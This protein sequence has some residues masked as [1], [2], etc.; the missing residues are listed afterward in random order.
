MQAAATAPS[1]ELWRWVQASPA[2]HLVSRR[3]PS[4][5][6][7]SCPNGLVLHDAVLARS[8]LRGRSEEAAFLEDAALA[9]HLRRG[10]SFVEPLGAAAGASAAWSG[11]GA[12]LVRRGLPKFFDLD[13]DAL[14]AA[15]RASPRPAPAPEPGGGAARLLQSSRTGR[16]TRV[17][18]LSKA[19]GENAQSFFAPAQQWV[20]C[21]KNVA[22]L[23]GVRADISSPQWS[24]HRYRFAR[25]VAEL[26]F[27]QLDP[28]A[29]ER[30][31]SLREA[32]SSRTLVGELVGGSA[33]LVDYAGLRTIIWFAIVPHHGDEACWP[34]SRSLAFLGE[35][36]LPVVSMELAGPSASCPGE[37][38]ETLCRMARATAAGSVKEDGEGYVVYVVAEGESTSD[39]SGRAAS[40]AEVI[41]IGK[42]KT[43]EYRLLRKLREK[44]KRFAR[45]GGSIT[46]DRVVSEYAAEVRGWALDEQQAEAH[47]LR[48]GR[49]CRYIFAEDLPPDVVDETFLDTLA[50]ADQHEGVEEPRPVAP[51]LCILSP[52]LLVGQ[53]LL[54]RLR[55]M[56]RG[57]HA[58]PG[59]EDL[60]P[61]TV[62][63]TGGASAAWH[64]AA[65]G[66]LPIYLGAV[67]SAVE[68]CCSL[69]PTDDP[70]GAPA[71]KR[72]KVAAGER[73]A[74]SACRAAEQLR[75]RC[76]F[77]LW[78]WSEQGCGRSLELAS[79][80]AAGG[81]GSHGGGLV[82]EGARFRRQRSPARRALLAKW[83]AHSGRL[84]AALPRPSALWLPQAPALDDRRA[85][86]TIAESYR[87]LQ[88]VA[89]EGPRAVVVAALPVGLPGMGKSSLMSR[90][91]RLCGSSARVLFQQGLR[92]T[93]G[94]RDAPAATVQ[95]P[96][97][98]AVS[99][100]SSDG[101]TAA[102]MRACGVS[103]ESCTPEELN[104]CRRRGA[105]R[106]R[107]S[108][109]EFLR[110]AKDDST[111][112]AEAGER[113]SV[114]P[115]YLLL[116]D[117]NYPP[118]ALR[119]EVEV[120][121]G[122]APPGLA[123]RLRGLLLG[124]EP[125]CVPSAEDPL[126]LEEEREFGP[127]QYP[128]GLDEVVECAARLMLR[129]GHDTLEGGETA[130]FVLLSFLQLHK[131]RQVAGET[132]GVDFV[133]VPFLSAA[134][135]LAS[136]ADASGG[137]PEAPWRRLEVR[138]LAREALRVLRPFGDP[139]PP[140]PALAALRKCLSSSGLR[141]P[142]ELDRRVHAQRC[143]EDA[144]RALLAAPQEK[145]AS[146]EAP[147]P[148]RY[149]ALSVHAQREELQSLLRRAS[150]AMAASAG[151]GRLDEPFPPQLYRRPAFLHVT[152]L[153]L[154][155]VVPS[156]AERRLL[157][158]SRRLLREAAAFDC[159][160]THLVCARGALACAV[161][162]ADRLRASGVP[163]GE[164]ARPHV[165]LCT[166]APWQP[167]HSGDVLA[168]VAAASLGAG[169]ASAG[170]EEAAGGRWLK[171]LRV[172]SGLLD[173]FVFRLPEARVLR[174]SPL[175][176]L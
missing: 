123:L 62:A 160:V 19:N 122:L 148:V 143:A 32:L 116:L 137:S 72:R 2:V 26:W 63:A 170:Q 156:E 16:G 126:V 141:C 135:Q 153:Y 165:T 25:T 145:G 164:A 73:Q 152:T 12:T 78:G 94:L 22:L 161:V 40:E 65:A 130:L 117:K 70:P 10:L 99:L 107:A 41:W 176:L 27:D 36:G 95:I 172:G 28:L 162:D 109:E 150:A 173:V 133:G 167:R 29:E 5:A 71:G 100:L 127:W 131:G 53:E 68:Q 64:R 3:L 59:G 169:G 50:S 168:A 4:I 85:L 90:L 155:G 144:A 166:R 151:A 82:G 110:F 76:L 6:A 67:P 84:L 34:P 43:I 23:A 115:V 80:P 149:V 31:S 171:A 54:G 159:A 129:S 74:L 14:G 106:Y 89:T 33:H 158:A 52:P 140:G 11:D 46:V 146:A 120:L 118:A 147:L 24:E 124:A 105:E 38:L 44:A 8:Y 119:R 17:L 113:P 1:A 134:G 35:S 45:G 88:A 79:G 37:A 92:A 75:D 7:P 66:H 81:A 57:G 97:L 86:S 56:L 136:W 69:G 13:T 132:P 93:A 96:R 175:R 30:R 112:L 39:G 58:E 48:L 108:I 51:A 15:L 9:R 121:S 77:V 139:G 83:R 18:K 101:F 154:G 49:L 61:D 102:E 47:R 138:A 21:S 104:S 163:L 60:C 55:G 111:A 87:A 174:Q 128:W 125:R 98:A 142:P 20:L 114:P 103:P 91:H 42:L 157:S